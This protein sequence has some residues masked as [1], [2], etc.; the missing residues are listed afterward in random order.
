MLTSMTSS[1]VYLESMSNLAEQALKSAVWTL[2]NGQNVVKL[3]RMLMNTGVASRA[4][5]RPPSPNRRHIPLAAKNERLEP[6]DR[7][8][9]DQH[10]V[11][12]FDVGRHA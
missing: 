9:F 3:I 4:V 6:F 5:F 11:V 8:L 2:G 7:R 10:T 12:A 1:S